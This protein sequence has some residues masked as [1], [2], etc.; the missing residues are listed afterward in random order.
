[1]QRGRYVF[2]GALTGALAI[3]AAAAKPAQ[4]QGA[5]QALPRANGSVMLT[6]LASPDPAVVGYNVYR[7]GSSLTADKAEL[8]NAQLVTATTAID[9]GPN[10]NGLPLGQPLTYFVR[11]VTMDA[12][13]KAVEISKSGETSVT[14]QN[15]TQLPP[16]DFLY[17]DIDTSN[18]GSVTREG[19]VLTIR[20]SGPPLWD[21]FD[22]HT[23]LAMPVTGDYQLTAAISAHPENADPDNGAGNAKVGIEIRTSPHKGEPASFLFSSVLRDPPVLNEGRKFSSGGTAAFGASD[24]TGED[25]TTYPLFL[26]LLKQGAI[27]TASVSHDGGNTYDQLGDPQ[28]FGSLPPVTYAGLFV[29]AD[30]D[31]QYTIGKFNIDSVKI[32]PK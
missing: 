19:N 26:R 8:A 9:A 13:G 32:E 15:A 21:K 30:R 10:G 25:A 6:W 14:P 22:G 7:R 28:D 11:G 5:L 3:T 31:G 20:A 17:Y 23:F 18:P 24:P 16:G 2:L 29:S 27:I 1:M 12:A 4:A